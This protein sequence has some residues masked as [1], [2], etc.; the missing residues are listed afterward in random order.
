MNRKAIWT[1]A[2]VA[3]AMMATPCFAATYNLKAGSTTVAMPGS[4][5]P[6]TMWGYGLNSA[7]CPS[8]PCPITIPGPAL[9]V[10]PGDTILTINLTNNLPVPTSIV[11]PGLTASF[12]P[13]RSADPQGRQRI[14]AFTTEAA[15]TNGTATYTWTGVKPGTYIYHSGSFPALQVQMG[16]YGVVKQDFAAGTAYPGITYTKEV[17]FVYSE[18]DPLLPARQTADYTKTRGVAGYVPRYFLVNGQPYTAGQAPIPVGNINDTVLIR[19]VNAGLKTHMPT[20]LGGYLNLIAEDANP[21]P[22]PKKQYSANLPPLKTIDAIWDPSTDGTYPLFD[23][24]LNLTT[25]GNLGGGMLTR[26][27]VG[28]AAAGPVA[29]NDSYTVAEDTALAQP[30]PGVLLN[31]TGPPPLTAVL[32]SPPSGAS[33][34]TLNSDGSFTYTPKLNFNGADTFTYKARDVAL[35]DSNIAIATITVTAVNDPP[36]ANPDS[37]STSAGTPVTINVLANDTDVDVNPLTVTNLGVPTSGT[38]VLN[39][40]QT[41]RYMPAAGFTGTAAFTYTAFD[42]SLAS[43]PATVTVTVSASVNQPPVAVDDAAQTTQNV[44][45]PINVV[46]N[47]YDPDGIVILASVVLTG[48]PAVAPFTIATTQGGTATN[49]KNGTVIYTPKRNFRGTDTFTYTV[50]D[51]QGATSNTATV[52]VNVVR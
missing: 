1:V 29:T 48:E 12:A 27:A 36:V 2:M 30:A 6:I 10:A 17:T 39:A 45:V 4:P 25:N 9:T 42:G 3:A 28:A 7:S 46:S 5:T 35:A 34:F 23:R 52:R 37:A 26:L 16:L 47:D 19:L 50:K 31:D 15:A 49:Q 38:V 40:D 33:S 32:V 13:V 20:L 24:S 14:R 11:I 22:Y 21:Y 51:N 43:A 41:V 8:A 18:I 44:S